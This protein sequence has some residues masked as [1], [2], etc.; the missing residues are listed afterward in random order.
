MIYVLSSAPSS[1]DVV[2]KMATTRRDLWSSTEPSWA[3]WRGWSPSWPRTT[4]ANGLWPS[5]SASV[6]PRSAGHDLQRSW[7]PLPALLTGSMFRVLFQ[8]AVAL[9]SPGD[10]RSRGAD[11]WGIRSQG[12]HQPVDVLA[13]NVRSEATQR[14]LRLT[15]THLESKRSERLHPKFTLHK[16]ER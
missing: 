8:A 6:F 7:E 9:S 15:R 14:R 3:Q 13:P 4:E 1:D 12:K 2:A 11:L 5:G 16:K 10:G